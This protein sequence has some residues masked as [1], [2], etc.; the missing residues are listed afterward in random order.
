M[1]RSA[2]LKAWPLLA[3]MALAGCAPAPAIIDH[4]SANQ[5]GR[6]RFLVLHFTDENFERSLD[7]LTNRH[8]NPVS[9]HYLVSRAGDLSQPSMAAKA[10]GLLPGGLS[11]PSMASESLGLLSA[12]YGRSA[13]TVLRLV[14]ESQRAWH[15]GPSRWQGHES[16]NGESIGVE[17]VYESHCLRE[18]ASGAS[19]WDVDATCAYPPYP[20]DQIDAVIELAR[21]ILKRNPEIEAARVV[22]HSDIQ[23]ENKTDPGPRFPWRQLAAAGVGAWYDEADVAWYRSEFAAR[24][25]TVAQDVLNDAPAAPSLKTV[26]EAL[27]AYGYGVEPTG[28][29]DLRTREVLSAFQSH[30]LP[31]RRSGNA[32]AQTVAT[33]F[34]LL[35]KYRPDELRAL[36]ER[37]AQVPDSPRATA[38]H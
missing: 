4:P 13:P 29:T 25:H 34:A 31:D 8:E 24:A 23:P 27:A 7:L 3:A 12:D 37:N 1:R 26:Q 20:A 11:R 21:G 22:G 9:A 30:F 14:D 33:L 5:D 28:L 10:L 36:H 38:R 2:N 15:A 6:V 19:P 32:D 16:L 17:I 35:A 18:R